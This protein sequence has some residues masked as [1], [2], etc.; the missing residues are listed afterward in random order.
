[1][2][3]SHPSYQHLDH[4]MR[5][6]W[7][8]QK[9]SK[10]GTMPTGGWN[11]KEECEVDQRCEVKTRQCR[12]KQTRQRLHPAVEPKQLLT[13]LALRTLFS[14]SSFNLTSRIHSQA[15][16][17]WST[18]FENSSP[19]YQTSSEDHWTHLNETHHYGK[20]ME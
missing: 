17:M 7:W 5:R 9:G 20:V 8:W 4:Y 16:S 1:M 19:L 2:P 10:L 11:R 13:G 15:G 14:K 18:S 3:S 6:N 12:A